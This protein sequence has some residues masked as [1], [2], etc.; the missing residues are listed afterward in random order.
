MFLALHLWAHA[1]LALTYHPTLLQSPSGNETPL[2][3]SITRDMQLALVSSRQINECMVFADLVNRSAYVSSICTSIHPWPALIL[4]TGTPYLVQ[5][6][7]VG[8]MAMT[9]EIKALESKGPGVSAV[10][11]LYTSMARQNLAGLIQ[12]V[13]RMAH[14]WA[15][16]DAVLEIIERR[17][18]CSSSYLRVT[19][20]NARYRSAPTFLERFAKR[21]HIVAGHGAFAPVQGRQKP[22]E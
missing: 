12:V 4:Q 2:N 8:T 14:V 18:S 15:G 19:A 21:L 6:L 9:H 1:V 20:E 10:D 11:V 7:F 17:K 16:A 22:S 3:Q 13:S 5:P